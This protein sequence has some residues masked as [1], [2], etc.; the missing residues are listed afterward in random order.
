MDGVSAA[1]VQGE[2]DRV[3]QT[4][5]AAS[6]EL[7]ERYVTPLPQLTD[8]GDARRPRRGTPQEDGSDMAV[9][10]FLAGVRK[11]LKKMGGTVW[12]AVPGLRGRGHGSDVGVN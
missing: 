6:R 11:N 8:S 7:A 10:T 12:V 9:R 5:P 3:S 1:A 2:L 4:L